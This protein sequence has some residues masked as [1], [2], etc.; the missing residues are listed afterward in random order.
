GAAWIKDSSGRYIYANE[1]AQ[2][3]FDTPID[4][5][6]DKTDDE[7]F[8]APVAEQFK[9]NDRLAIE[10]LQNNLTIETLP[11]PDGVHSSIVN[12]FPIFGPEGT[13][14]MVGGVAIDITDRI[15]IE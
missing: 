10:R 11:Q 3:I 1:T 12:K 2:R 14:Q 15:R 13:V 8:P 6:K 7:I 5:L 9:L 4:K